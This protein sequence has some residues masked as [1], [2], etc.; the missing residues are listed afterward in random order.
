M[1]EK[2]A[3]AMSG[4]KDGVQPKDFLY[5]K[6]SEQATYFTKEKTYNGFQNSIVTVNA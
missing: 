1:T 2:D 5:I 3:L 4:Y 6:D